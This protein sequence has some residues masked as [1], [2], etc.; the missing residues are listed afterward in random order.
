MFFNLNNPG[1]QVGFEHVL[2]PLH[3]HLQDVQVLTFVSM[4]RLPLSFLGNLSIFHVDLLANSLDQSVL[5]WQN[6]WRHFFLS[7]KLL[8]LE[9]IDVQRALISIQFIDH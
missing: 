3:F 1:S 6:F 7:Q 9:S 5:V 2:N 4:L 8:H